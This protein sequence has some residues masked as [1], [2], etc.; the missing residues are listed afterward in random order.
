MGKPYLKKSREGNGSKR[1]NMIMR[2][3]MAFLKNQLYKTKL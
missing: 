2:V 1:I 3:A